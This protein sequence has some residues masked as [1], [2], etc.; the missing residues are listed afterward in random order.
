MGEIWTASHRTSG[1]P[2]AVKVVGGRPLPPAWV[3]AFADEVRAVAALDHPGIVRVFD[4]GTVSAEASEASAGRLK[5][6]FPWLAMEYAGGG[7]L[8]ALGGKLGWAAQR[9]LLLGLLDALS[10]AHAR[11][12]LHL[13]LKPGNLVIATSADLRPGAKLTDFGVARLLP[14]VDVDGLC[15]DPLVGSPS[16]MAPEQI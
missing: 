11:S 4:Q 6:G 1:F 3:E 5:R 13:D 9:Q 7:D 10:H 14:T 8:R 12:V 15:I 16:Y 2:A